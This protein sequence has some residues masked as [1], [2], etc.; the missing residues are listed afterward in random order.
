MKNKHPA[1]YLLLLMLLSSCG[2]TT[3]A[4]EETM[5][6]IRVKNTGESA[7]TDALVRLD[8][9]TLKEKYPGLDFS[10]IKLSADALLPFQANDLNQDGAADE[11]AFLID[12]GPGEEKTVSIEPLPKGES[13]PEFKKRTQAEISHKVGGRWE[14]REYQGGAFE[15]TTYLRVP[16]EHTDHSWFI[17]YEGPGWESDKVGYRLYLDW[18]NATDIFG[19]K[20]SGMVL[21][22]VGQDGF[23][24]YHEAADWGMDI[25]KVGESLGIGA[26]G[27]W[28]GEKAL[29]VATT[30]SITC[31]IPLNGPVQSMARIRYYGWNTGENTVDLTSEYSIHAGSRLTR[32]SL[33]LSAPLPNI[34]TG[35]VRHE[36]AEIVPDEGQ[37]D[38]GF[39]A[40]WGPQSLDGGQL[41]MAVLYPKS[42]LLQ[43]TEDEHSHVAVLQPGASNSL[44]YYFLAAWEQEPDGIKTKDEFINYLLQTAGALS[45]PPEVAYGK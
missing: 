1:I 4:N 3:P 33:S 28:T 17:R 37:S 43:L 23:D 45:A 2:G 10:N 29:R 40:T 14:G 31:S 21:Q 13:L 39:L 16:P 8:A 5:Q 7:R 34:C 11:I 42:Q 32:H 44:A 35:I 26:P 25:L 6:V 24:S 15:N 36:N 19:K 27:F 18:R 30:D 20:T 41:G 22:D 9:R 38:W 12:L